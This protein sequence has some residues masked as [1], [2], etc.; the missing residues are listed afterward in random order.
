MSTIPKRGTIRINTQFASLIQEKRL[1]V[2]TGRFSS[3]DND[4]KH[5]QKNT[6]SQSKRGNRKAT[7]EKTIS[8]SGPSLAHERGPSIVSLLTIP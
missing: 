7:Q 3:A 8:L 5:A 4:D 1:H 6:Q 2:W